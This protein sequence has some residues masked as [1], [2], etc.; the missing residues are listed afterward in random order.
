[1]TTG[2]LDIND[3]EFNQMRK[4]IYD[5]FGINLTEQKRSLLVSRLQ[6]YIIS[7]GFITFSNYYKFL[8]SDRTE[9]ELGL[10]VDRI[11][12]NHT[13]FNREKDHFE[14]FQ[15]KILPDLTS[16]LKNGNCKDIR[17]W[18]AGC[19]TGEEAYTILMLM[20]EFLGVQYSSWNAGILAIHMSD[21]IA[22]TI[23]G[24]FLG[25]EIHEVNEDV[26][27]SI[28]EVANM[29][30]GNIKTVLSEN[31]KDINLSLPSTI[32]GTEYNFQCKDD[33]EQVVVPFSAPQGK[34]WV[35]LQLEKGI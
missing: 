23:T 3:Q 17:I 35:E 5:R 30:G 27:D 14:F 22:K 1:M 16:R 20:H 19:S 34:F 8:K 24:N 31:G 9:K 25:M 11:S 33:T 10:L 12:T 29:L 13:Y 7:S 2:M 32:C 6:K 4:L 28:G 15:K 26:Q 21:E 18:S